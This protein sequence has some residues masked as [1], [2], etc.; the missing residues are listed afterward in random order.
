MEN[1]K[2]CI[3]SFH[4]KIRMLGCKIS[5]LLCLRELEAAWRNG[6]PKSITINDGGIIVKQ[7]TNNGIILTQSV[8][9]LIGE[10]V[11]IKV[12]D[13]SGE[14]GSALTWRDGV[15]IAP[16]AAKELCNVIRDY[17]TAD[18]SLKRD[19]L[20]MTLNATGIRSSLDVNIPIITNQESK[21]VNQ[22]A[23]YMCK[24]VRVL[25]LSCVEM[26]QQQSKLDI[27]FYYENES[28]LILRVGNETFNLVR[29][30]HII[31]ENCV[32]SCSHEYTTS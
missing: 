28:Y 18:I 14:F 20:H 17:S 7:K 24:Y 6:T 2:M 16:S 5:G 3:S 12:D 29:S 32:G 11:A 22:Q 25:L 8:L 4:V 30:L 15:S 19:V 13:L 26:L 9:F 21:L 1:I 31:S 10:D 23:T 27:R